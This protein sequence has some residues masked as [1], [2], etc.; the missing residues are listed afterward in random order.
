MHFVIQTTY[1]R[2]TLPET[3]S[4]KCSYELQYEFTEVTFLHRCSPLNLLHIFRKYF[5]NGISQGL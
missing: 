2:P 1:V 5:Y 4:E 3:V